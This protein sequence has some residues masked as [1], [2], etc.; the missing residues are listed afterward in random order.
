MSRTIKNFSETLNDKKKAEKFDEIE[1]VLQEYLPGGTLFLPVGK[2]RILAKV[3]I[4]IKK[5]MGPCCTHLFSWH[6]WIDASGNLKS[7]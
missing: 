3:M 4:K 6:I 1:R 5:V 7:V 2:E